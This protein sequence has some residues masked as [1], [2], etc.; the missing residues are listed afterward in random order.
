MS[1]T[2]EI[3]KD[4]HSHALKI[5]DRFEEDLNSLRRNE[6]L[7]HVRQGLTEFATF[8]EHVLPPG[9]GGPFP[10]DDR[11]ESPCGSTGGSYA[12]GA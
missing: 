5:L 10:S 4:D 8:L 6:N 11:G 3:F 12:E 1:E 7:A 9:R 2:I